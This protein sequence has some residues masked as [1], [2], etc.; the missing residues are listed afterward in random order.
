MR[1]SYGRRSCGSYSFSLL[2]RDTKLIRVLIRSLTQP[3]VL[4]EYDEV[5]LTYHNGTHQMKVDQAIVITI[6]EYVDMYP[7]LISSTVRKSNKSA[8]VSV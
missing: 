1:L 2:L 3:A 7:S 6:N 5:I 8:A 4:K